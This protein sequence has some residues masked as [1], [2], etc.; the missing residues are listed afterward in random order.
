MTAVFPYEP[1]PPIAELPVVRNSPRHSICEA[2]DFFLGLIVADQDV[3]SSNAA[4][5]MRLEFGESV[6]ASIMQAAGIRRLRI[7]H[8][9][10]TQGTTGAPG[11]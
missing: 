6:T 8:E 3:G 10:G 11:Q 5:A 7:K 2:F 1:P 9:R 4:E